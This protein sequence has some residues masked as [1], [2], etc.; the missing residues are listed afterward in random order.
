M[1]VHSIKA[2]DRRNMCPNSGFK[3][4]FRLARKKKVS[5]SLVQQCS[6]VRRALLFFFYK[7]FVLNLM[8]ADLTW[9]LLAILQICLTSDWIV[10]VMC[11]NR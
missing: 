11:V 3:C 4:F 7:T 1:F 5:R 6:V 2:V 10:V 9:Y 8:N